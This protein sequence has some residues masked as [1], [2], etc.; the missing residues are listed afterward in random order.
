MKCIN[1]ILLAAVFTSVSFVSFGSYAKPVTKP[2]N[3]A[4]QLK[5]DF[6]LDKKQ[7]DFFKSMVI[8]L[9]ANGF[10]KMNINKVK[11]YY[12]QDPELRF[13]DADGPFHKGWDNYKVWLGKIFNGVVDKQKF[14]T[15]DVHSVRLS[16]DIV[17]TTLIIDNKTR[18]TS[19]ELI[20]SAMRLS[21]IWMQSEGSWKIVHEHFSLWHGKLA[22]PMGYPDTGRQHIDLD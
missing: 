4:S 9:V 17:L 20:D 19:G 1:K 16:D 10:G 21:F 11:S 2:I 13:A 12:N 8:D 14:L 3:V 6:S 22:G 5:H 7:Q 18:L 15:R